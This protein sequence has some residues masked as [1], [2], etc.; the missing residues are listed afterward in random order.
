MHGRCEGKS[1]KRTWKHSGKAMWRVDS[2][3]DEEGIEAGEEEDEASVE[4]ASTAEDEAQ[5]LTKY[6]EV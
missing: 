1:S 2:I 3:V 4:P 6:K 5:W